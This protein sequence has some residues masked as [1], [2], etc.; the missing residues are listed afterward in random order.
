M[1]KTK[2]LSLIVSAALVLSASQGVTVFADTIPQ[3]ESYTVD[4][5]VYD[6][7]NDTTGAGDSYIVYH[8][9]QNRSFLDTG[10]VTSG[11]Q[12]T[13][14]QGIHLY[15]QYLPGPGYRFAG[16]SSSNSKDDI[17]STEQYWLYSPSEDTAIYALFEESEDATITI[18]WCSPEGEELTEPHEITASVGNLLDTAVDNY[19]YDLL[20]D[21]YLLSDEYV[22][23]YYITLKPLSEYSSYVE[24]DDSY[25]FFEDMYMYLWGSWGAFREEIP[26]DVDIYCNLVRPIDLTEVTVKPP[27]IGTSSDCIPEVTVPSDANYYVMGGQDASNWAVL[28]ENNELVPFE[29]TFEE[30]E[31]YYIDNLW[32]EAK[33]G[34]YFCTDEDDIVVNNATLHSA[35]LAEYNP[36]QGL[37]LKVEAV[38]PEM[39]TLTLHSSSVNGIDE[40]DPI[41]FTVPAGTAYTDILDPYIMESGKTNFFDTTGYY[42]GE[43]MIIRSPISEFDHMKDIKDCW[44]YNPSISNDP[45]T[46]TQYFKG[47]ITEDEDLYCVLSTPV[48]SA[49]IQLENPVEGTK[50]EGDYIPGFSVPEGAHYDILLEEDYVNVFWYE[51]DG[52]DD[53][54]EFTGTFE[55]GRKYCVCFCL[56]AVP[57]YALV[58]PDENITLTNGVLDETYTMG[59][60]GLIYVTLT[61]EK[62][63]ISVTEGQGQTINANEDAVFVFKS[64]GDDSDTFE[65]HTG[66]MV[67]GTAVPAT[68]TTADGKTV[69]AMTTAEG[70]LIVT[71]N[72]AYLKTLSYGQHTLTVTFSS[73][74]SVSAMFTIAAPSN[75]PSTGETVSPALITGIVLISTA[76]LVAGACTVTGKKKKQD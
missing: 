21:G 28:D 37:T 47:V 53:Y 5:T 16:W 22:N 76:I 41:S 9:Y 8:H 7:T 75:V 33:F 14:E 39:V 27:V 26:G 34:Y 61:A 48:T 57:G 72:S 23:G 55:A 12:V 6:V 63:T 42:D 59:R 10:E 70:S 52:D 73:G 20:S 38:E 18:H 65:T 60:F 58:Y 40:Q 66:T 3:N 50:V 13:V 2:V 35:K 46:N 29:G 69:P 45:W 56:E 30:G 32:V 25:E 64:N 51:I 71:L 24:I 36:W 49:E 1:K 44:F 67:D 4:L 11:E 31:D 19:I 74:Q 43:C 15:L 17:I 54:T 62:E 68:V